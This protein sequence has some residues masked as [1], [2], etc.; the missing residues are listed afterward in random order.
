MDIILLHANAKEKTKSLRISNLAFLLVVFKWHRG[1]ERVNRPWRSS[2][3]TGC[4]W[5]ILIKSANYYPAVLH[6]FL[7]LFFII[8]LSKK[9]LCMT[10]RCFAE[11][12]SCSC[13]CYVIISTHTPTPTSDPILGGGL[14]MVIPADT[15][16]MQQ[17]NRSWGRGGG[18]RGAEGVVVRCG[19]MDQ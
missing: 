11:D 10:K 12:V 8:L 7:L 9:I 14:I 5:V 17:K 13:C 15:S 19:E 2:F 4:Q 1:G 6:Y 3:E 18:R 16:V